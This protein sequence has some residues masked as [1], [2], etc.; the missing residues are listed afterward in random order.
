M[1]EIYS[2]TVDQAEIR[3]KLVLNARYC[4]MYFFGIRYCININD[5]I[6]YLTN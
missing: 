5:V 4:I 6:F 3:G 1:F 2:K